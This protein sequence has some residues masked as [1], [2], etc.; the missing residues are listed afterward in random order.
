M[1]FCCWKLS[2]GGCGSIDWVIGRAGKL[3][4]KLLVVPA[5]FVMDA[6]SAEAIRS[7]VRDG[8]TVVMTAFSA[9]MDEHGQWFNT[10]LPGRL[11]DIFGIRIE[12][13]Y[14]PAAAPEF[15]LDGVTVKTAISFYEVL[16]PRG[17]QPLASFTN[18]PELVCPARHIL[19]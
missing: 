14:R 5:D 4:Y 11:N 9:K 6:A 16:E 13:F 2:A 3:D 17:A 7:Y 12:E 1:L 10:P 18:T 15:L 19:Y 8:G